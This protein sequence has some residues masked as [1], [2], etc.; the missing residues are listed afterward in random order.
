V[1]IELLSPADDAMKVQ[2]SRSVHSAALGMLAAVTPEEHSVAITKE[3]MGDVVRFCDADVV[4]IT[5]MTKQANRAYE[6]ADEYRRRGAKIVFG[7]IHP[8]VLPNEALAHADAVVVGEVET[9]WPIVL[10]DLLAGTSR[11]IYRSSMPTDMGTVPAYRRD[12]FVKRATIAVETV[13]A[14]RGCPYDCEFCSAKLFFGRSLRHRPVEQ[15][16]DEIRRTGNKNI[17]FS[18]DNILGDPKYASE[19]FKT[20]QPLGINWVGQASFRLAIRDIELLGLARSSGCAALF[21][22]FESLYLESQRD[23][24]AFDKN[25]AQSLDELEAGSCYLL[26]APISQQRMENDLA[27]ATIR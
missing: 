4:G 23:A 20:L 18:D 2:E 17:F 10:R 5:A 27:A 11:E 1:R 14:T 9:L 12:L 21:F 8:L 25:G 24:K 3:H 26:H 22:G 7:G 15:V 16:V 6:I 19:L 13:Q